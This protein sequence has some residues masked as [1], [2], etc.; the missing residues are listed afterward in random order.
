[1]RVSFMGILFLT[2]CTNQK[3]PDE[4]YNKGEIRR[5]MR[6]R[7]GFSE[8]PGCDVR[9][10]F[11]SQR[12]PPFVAPAK[13]MYRGS[14]SSSLKP[15]AE[16]LSDADLCFISAGYIFVRGID[17]IYYYDCRLSGKGGKRKRLASELT[18]EVK[19][20]FRRRVSDG[21]YGT[22]LI[23]L[24]GIYFE[25]LLGDHPTFLHIINEESRGELPQV[26]VAGK[27]SKLVEI[28]SINEDL[29]LDVSTF[30]RK[31]FAPLTNAQKQG[32][33]DEI[34]QRN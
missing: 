1:M 19:E 8:I 28:K 15:F 9:G 23:V 26:F 32:I 10:N 30:R 2:N 16:R 14:F 13:E 33:L 21:S 27:R 7:Y 20:K 3:W 18:D 12:D 4:L 31:G 17:L 24:S 34:E 6:N 22:I 11:P 5:E 29:D 25:T